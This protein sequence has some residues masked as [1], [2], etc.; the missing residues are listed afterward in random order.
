MLTCCA[1]LANR[2]QN[3]FVDKPQVVVNR[4]IDVVLER[5]THSM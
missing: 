2:Y 1:I 4:L 3:R 5:L